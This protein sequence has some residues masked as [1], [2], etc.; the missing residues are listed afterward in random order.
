ME[1]IL[2]M[3]SIKNKTCFPERSLFY[4]S[5]IVISRMD[6]RQFKMKQDIQKSR[7]R[8]LDYLSYDS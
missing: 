4:D 2:A 3:W 5:M 6:L 7:I 1:G 8:L